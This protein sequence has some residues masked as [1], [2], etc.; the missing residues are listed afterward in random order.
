MITEQKS[1]A[2]WNTFHN[3]PYQRRL[4]LPSWS[5]DWSIV[6]TRIK[7][8]LFKG[9]KHFKADQ[10]CP[11]SLQWYG[12][13]NILALRGKLID[14]ITD[15]R[16][17]FDVPHVGHGLV[18]EPNTLVAATLNHFRCLA[19]LLQSCR[20]LYDSA[21]SEDCNTVDIKE[22]HW[23]AWRAMVGGLRDDGDLVNGE[24][25]Q[26]YQ[27]YE[28]YI[29]HAGSVSVYEHLKLI[30]HSMSLDRIKGIAAY[31][32]A[33]LEAGKERQFTVTENGRLGWVPEWVQADDRV[34]IIHGC[35]L[36]AVIRP[37]QDGLW[38]WV[39]ICYLD[40]VM[41]GEAMEDDRY[42]TEDITLC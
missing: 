14:K 21:W 31:S 16:I 13:P 39:S 17:Y 37:R 3:S 42:V 1:F 35:R 27:D 30:D 9:W 32:R 29:Q 40:G 19:R 12:D 34:A 10:V 24:Y 36:P 41:F 18:A 6:D 38:T 11:A 28:K 25:F 2:V 33:V 26:H 15:K 7:M 22:N 23:R 5:P 8:R 4:G 20:A